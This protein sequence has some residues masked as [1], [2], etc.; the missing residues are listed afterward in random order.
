MDHCGIRNENEKENVMTELM[1][2]LDAVAECTA[3]ALKG[4]EGWAKAEADKATDHAEKLFKAGRMDMNTFTRVVKR[5]SGNHSARKQQL[6]SWG[7]LQTPERDS[8]EKRAILA[9]MERIDKAEDALLK[10]ITSAEK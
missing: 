5:V 1:T 2:E 4:A 3:V 7:I 10:D 6:A 8:A 9:A